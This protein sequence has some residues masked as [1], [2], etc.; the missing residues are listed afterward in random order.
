[1]P[2]RKVRA[3]SPPAK[4]EVAVEEVALKVLAEAKPLTTKL[5]ETSMK[6]AKVEVAVVE[7]AR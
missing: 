1:M 6:P 4:V 3:E 5:R 7:V 2:I